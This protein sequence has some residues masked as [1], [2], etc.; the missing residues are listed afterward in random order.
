[1]LLITAR[2][3]Q[4]PAQ[5][6]RFFE[7]LPGSLVLFL[8]PTD[9]RQTDEGDRDTAPIARLPAHDQTTS[10][11]LLRPLVIF[12]N[13]RQLPQQNLEGGHKAAFDLYF[14]DQIEPFRGGRLRTIQ[15]ALAESHPA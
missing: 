6:Q 9:G 3:T 14:V 1:M 5:C 8:I 4:L 12:P 10:G 2:L 15:V 7:E 11:K 13:P